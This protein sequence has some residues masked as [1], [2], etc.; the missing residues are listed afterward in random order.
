MSKSDLSWVLVKFLGAIL[1]YMGVASIYGAFVGWM[2]V[3]EVI[4][5]MPESSRGSVLVPLRALCFGALLQLIFG[6]YLVAS[7]KMLYD[8]LMSVPFG[9]KDFSSIPGSIAGVELPEEEL[10]QFK[11]WL[12][13]NSQFA[14][15][16]PVD[17]V[18]LFRDA[19]AEEKK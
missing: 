3:K 11:S 6:L 1:L 18:A 9:F 7:G 8:V 12:A 5:D 17:Q 14:D 15:R 10:E 19:Q 4:E 2:S 16:P 13:Q